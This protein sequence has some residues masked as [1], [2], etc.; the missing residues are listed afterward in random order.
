M[1]LLV[2]EANNP[3]HVYIST[4]TSHILLNTTTF[5]IVPISIIVLPAMK[6]CCE[7]F[8]SLKA[9][10]INIFF[11]IIQQF[12]LYRH[13]RS[14]RVGT[15]DFPQ[16]GKGFT[17]VSEDHSTTASTHYGLNLGSSGNLYQIRVLAQSLSGKVLDHWTSPAGTS[18]LSNSYLSK[19]H[20]GLASYMGSYEAKVQIFEAKLATIDPANLLK[21]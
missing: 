1:Q 5:Y 13:H 9:K 7:I 20:S 2:S 18:P 12:I 16:L 3:H 10:L 14:L 4:R 21:C 19:L 17:K 8:S 15:G 6:M 11:W